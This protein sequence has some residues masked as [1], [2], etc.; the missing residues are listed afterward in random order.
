M[1]L[2]TDCIN[3]CGASPVIYSFLD[4]EQRIN[5]W[6]VPLCILIGTMQFAPLGFWNAIFVVLHLLTDPFT[7]I[8]SLLSKLAAN[9]QCYAR[10]LKS[11]HLPS[12]ARKPVAVIIAALEEWENCLVEGQN[13]E[14]KCFRNI[15]KVA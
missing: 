4:I 14:T 1:M 13:I 11:E 10:C 2:L 15:R 9:Q 7:S 5:E 12:A 6:V 3:T 8:W